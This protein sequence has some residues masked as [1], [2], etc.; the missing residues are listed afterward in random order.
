MVDYTALIKSIASGD[1][2]AADSLATAVKGAGS[3]VLV[4][5]KILDGLKAAAEDKKSQP[6]REAAFAAYT[7]IAKALTGAALKSEPTLLRALP[8]VLVEQGDKAAPVKSAADEAGK[9]LIAYV[10]SLVKDNMTVAQPYLCKQLPVILNACGDKKVAKELKNQCSDA[11]KNIC[12]NLSLNGLRD[13]VTTLINAQD[14]F[15][16]KTGTRAAALSAIASFSESAP[17]QLGFALTQIVP[18]ISKSVVDTDPTI[19][20]LGEAALTAA[21]DVI[22][23]RDLEHMTGPIVRSVTHPDEVKEIMHKLAGVTFVSSVESP[24]LAMVTPLLVR[25]LASGVT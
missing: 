19:S 13:I 2:A 23:N 7:A 16:S 17:E 6:A 18:E 1:K 20:E 22:G 4:S 3:A 24:A 14:S 12:K 8:V 10:N 5:S 21:C 15:Q 9:A 11:A 25:G